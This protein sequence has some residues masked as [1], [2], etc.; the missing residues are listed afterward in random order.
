MSLCLENPPD[1]AL[2]H[3]DLAGFPAPR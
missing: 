3:D 2:W 1:S